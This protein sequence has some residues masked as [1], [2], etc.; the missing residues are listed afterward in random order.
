MTHQC[1][2]FSPCGSILHCWQ[3]RRC[4]CQFLLRVFAFWDHAHV[5]TT[6]ARVG[7]INRLFERE[8]EWNSGGHRQAVSDEL[9]CISRVVNGANVWRGSQASAEQGIKVLGVPLGHTNFVDETI[10]DIR[11]S[12]R[13]SRLSLICSS[14]PIALLG[15]TRRLVDIRVR[16]SANWANCVS[17]M[18]EKHPQVAKEFVTRLEAGV[19]TP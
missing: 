6:P 15:L 11:C 8:F 1:H 18:Q 10:R 14:S 12:L 16:I 5:T 3:S 7:S 17:M 4:C 13:G 2:F 19:E 9:E